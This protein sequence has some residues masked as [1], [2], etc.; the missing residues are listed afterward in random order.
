MVL[1]VAV[2]T[3][4]WIMTIYFYLQLPETI[5]TSFNPEGRAIF[6]G[7]KSVMFFFPVLDT[8]I[9]LVA[10]ALSFVI[11][12]MIVKR[13]PRLILRAR[14]MSAASDSSGLPLAVKR[15]INHRKFSI[16]LL[17]LLWSNVTLTAVAFY[18]EYS[19][20]IGRPWPHLIQLLFSIFA[21][22]VIVIAVIAIYHHRLDKEIKRYE[23]KLNKSDK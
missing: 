7:P 16:L 17:L 12:P 23:P 5:P 4:C 13:F 1:N 6:W 18:A 22:L 8:F 19:A 14:R 20:F 21:F 15:S 9:A 2:T 10:L 11:M 3:F